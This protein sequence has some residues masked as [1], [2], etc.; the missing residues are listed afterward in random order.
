MTFFFW[1]CWWSTSPCAVADDRETRVVHGDAR[2]YHP[3]VRTVATH[4]AN[5][6]GQQEYTTLA[7]L[8]KWPGWSTIKVERRKMRDKF[9]VGFCVAILDALCEKQSSSSMRH[10][11]SCPS[12]ETRILAKVEAV[13][14]S[15]GEFY[16]LG[17]GWNPDSTL[18]FCELDLHLHFG[19]D[20]D[21]HKIRERV[22]AWHAKGELAS[23]I[24]L[25]GFQAITD[26]TAAFQIVEVYPCGAASKSLAL[27]MSSF[28]SKLVAARSPRRRPRR[29]PRRRRV[30]TSSAAARGLSAASPRRVGSRDSR[31]LARRRRSGRRCRL[32]GLGSQARSKMLQGAPPVQGVHVVA[33]AR[34]VHRGR[35]SAAS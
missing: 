14:G 21:W 11:Y 17:A 13:L 9:H 1:G 25:S 18:H 35:N 16:F 28:Y 4:F 19:V 2:R 27:G 31:G 24:M 7:A 8:L 15:A 3:L 5:V 20:V 33:V 30:A 34:R 32:D 23:N 22:E 29:G 6:L 10:I 26:P 12:D